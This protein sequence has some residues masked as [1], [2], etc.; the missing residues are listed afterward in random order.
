MNDYWFKVV[1][2]V[3]CIDGEKLY[4]CVEVM[5]IFG[6]DVCVFVVFWLDDNDVNVYMCAKVIVEECRKGADWK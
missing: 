5:W 6:C 1:Y 3:Y 4:E 2:D